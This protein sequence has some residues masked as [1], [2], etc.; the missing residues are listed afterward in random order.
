[1]SLL[2]SRRRP[3]P[4]HAR[5][6][7]ILGSPNDRIGLMLVP[8]ETGLLVG[9]KQQMLDGVVPSQ[10]EYGSAPVYR[11]RTWT[12]RPT[13]GYGERVQSS[14]GDKRY[15]WGL[16]IQVSGGLFGKGPLLH[17]IVPSAVAGSGYGVV[18][19]IDVPTTAD[20]AGT[21]QQIILAGQK[22]Y[23][24]TD[25]LNAGQI[26]SRD[27]APYGLTDGVVFQGGFAGA[28]P[29]LYVTHD[30]GQ[31]WERQPDGTWTQCTLPS[32]FMAYRLEVVGTELWAA[33]LT[34]SVVRN[35]KADPKVATNWSGPIFVG[36]PSV[37][38]SALRQTA[39]QLVI[40]KEDG[41]LYTINADGSTNDLFPGVRVPKNWENGFR[42]AAWMNA[43]WFRAGPS[44]YRLDMP[45]ANLTATGPGKL[46]DNASPV[47]GESRAFCGWG[48]YLAYLALWNPQTSTSYLLSYG[49]W[50]MR[51]SETGG[52]SAEFEDQFDG[53]LA[54][55]PGKKV[56]AMGVSGATGQDR[57]YIGFDDGTWDWLKLV[58]HPLAIDGGGEFNLGPAEIVFPLH[59][60]MFQADL[61]HWLGFSIFGPVIRVG[62]EA[63]L[64]YRIMASAGA[65]PMDPTGDWLLLG[66][67][68]ANGQRIDAPANMVGNAVSLKLS[69]ANSNT[70]TTPVLET[71]AIH[72]RVVPA[73]KRDISGTIDGRAV[74]SRLDGAA[75]RPNPVQVHRAMMDFAARPGS[76]AIELPDETVNEVAM[77]D[78]RETQL[79]MAAGGGQAWAIDFQATQFRILT[80]YGIWRRAR[81]TRIRDFRG[82]TIASMRTI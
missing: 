23:R 19:F 78:Y 59:H 13:G 66:E 24:R 11:E 81:G 4:Y 51:Q 42:V 57:L 50:E 80:V 33:D 75:Y 31:L 39:N 65:P 37:R 68:T 63:T 54:H 32:G 61:K 47:R 45:G 60:A 22:A 21:T 8:K 48:G 35:V 73:F 17:P 41:S 30:G 29:N 15:Y 49:S 69:L 3:W 10:Q 34:T 16:D 36:N 43:L 27:F 82:Y 70:S 38:I 6:G 2:S 62:D 58:Q 46:F 56:T 79:P 18:R 25:D 67:F 28:K 77:F 1:M 20:P 76:F 53:A 44:F 52:A 9:R 74:I 55:W 12:A 14:W 5:L 26:V 71:L 64:Y 40:F 7:S 72:E